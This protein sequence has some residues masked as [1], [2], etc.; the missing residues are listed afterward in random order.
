VILLYSS[1]ADAQMYLFQLFGMNRKAGNR[2]EGRSAMV[3]GAFWHCTK[4]LAEGMCD[5]LMV[6]I[7]R[8]RDD[9][10]GG[11]KVILVKE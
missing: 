10:V 9:N 5:L 1:G 7:S 2:I 8:G 11:L 6:E 4:A 3:W